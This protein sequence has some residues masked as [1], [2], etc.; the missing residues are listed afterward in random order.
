MNRSQYRTARRSIRDNGQRYSEA[1]ATT[2]DERDTFKRLRLIDK[3]TDHLAER[4]RWMNNPD[5]VP[6]NIIR[7]T[8]TI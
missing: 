6:A 2:Q 7:L 3:Q 1:H 8:T 4:V 5:T